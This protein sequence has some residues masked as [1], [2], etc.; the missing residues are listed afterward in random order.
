M[1]VPPPPPWLASILKDP[2]EVVKIF[3][4]TGKDRQREMHWQSNP[5]P[6]TWAAMCL[7]DE[8]LVGGKRGGG[9]SVLLMA[10]PALGDYTLSHDDPARVSMLNDAS[11]R[12]LFLREEY[13]SMLEFVEQAVEFYRP[14]GGKATGTPVKINFKSGARLMFGHLGDEEAFNKYKGFNLTFIGIEELTQIR[15]LKRYLKLKGSLRSVERRIGNRRFPGLRTQLMASTNPDGPGAPWIKARFIEVKSGGVNAPW[16][17]PLYDRITGQRRIF[18]PFGVEANPYLSEDTPEGRRYRGNLMAQDDVTRRQWMDG[19]WNA[20]SSVYFSEYRPTGPVGKQEEEKYPWARH[21][22]KPVDLKP[23]WFRWGSGDWGYDHPAAFHKACRNEADGR[24]HIY[25][26]MQVRRVGSFELGALLA[27]WWHSDLLALKAAGQAAS[28]VIHIGGDAFAKDD[29]SRTKAQQMEAG[30]KEVLGP[31]GALLMK[32]DETEQEAALRDPKRARAL[33]EQRTKGMQGHMHIVLK[34]LYI[35]RVT[36]WDYMREMLR[37][38][39]AVLDLQTPEARD[40]YLRDVMAAE[41]IEAYERHAADL[42]TLKPEVLPKMLIWDRCKEA[43]RFLKVAQ[44]DMRNDDD[45]S[46]ISRREDVLKMNADSEG[47]N[48]D[49]AGESLRNACAAFK[50]IETTMPKSYYVN[51]RMSVIQEDHVRNFGEELTD[52]TRLA[53]IARTQAA[54]YEVAHNSGPKQFTFPRGGSQRHRVN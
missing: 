52:P 10:K 11:Y 31:Y 9:K 19:D 5:G 1:I 30:I 8:I 4:L 46:K 44:R 45:P 13:Q 23:W 29:A 7:Y 24:V 17:M 54:R 27:K 41:G 28:V 6:Q 15:T 36:G 2:S 22:T 37:F 20:G 53:Q 25:D 49:D 21:I 14:F 18:I 26:E 40:Q 42:R 33:F 12:G 43:D 51:E 38:R 32:Y 50:E 35:E 47:M 3:K 48:G 39:P 16:N 34:P